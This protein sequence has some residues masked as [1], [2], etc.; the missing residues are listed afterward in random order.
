M[1]FLNKVTTNG[2]KPIADE[3]AKCY[4]HIL[5]EKNIKIN[6]E[7]KTEQELINIYN[8]HIDQALKPK[9]SKSAFLIFC[10]YHKP[11]LSGLDFKDCACKLGEMWNQADQSE[12]QQI[13]DDL[14]NSWFGKPCKFWYE[15][16][17]IDQD[18]W[19]RAIVKKFNQST[20]NLTITYID[21]VSEHQEEL[22]LN[23]DE[24]IDTEYFEWISK[25]TYD[26]ESLD[27]HEESADEDSESAD[28]ESES[29]DEESEDSE[30]ELA[31]ESDE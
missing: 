7:E 3:L 22:T 13:A 29:A 26:H 12:W 14:A 30:D 11:G 10:E 17:D 9:K 25:H 15:A 23:I 1:D 5:A 4:I 31:E 27:D 28:E 2:V 20:R 6:G 24:W 19:V 16:S 21:P 18:R 8:K